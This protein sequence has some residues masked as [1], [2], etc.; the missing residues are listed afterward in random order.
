MSEDIAT[1]AGGCFWCTEAAFA[2]LAGV[3]RVIPGYIGGSVPDPDYEQVCS[4]VTGHAEAVRI[5]FDP[6][7]IG[8]DDLLDVFFTVHDPT[9]L[10]RQGHDVGTQY[11]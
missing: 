9:Q 2:A 7:T 6:E 11:R 1:L 3:G 5:H 4:G 10:N 8:Y